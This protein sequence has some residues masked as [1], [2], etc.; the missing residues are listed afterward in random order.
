VGYSD[1]PAYSQ[2]FTLLLPTGEAA[3]PTLGPFIVVTTLAE[4]ER[5]VISDQL[6]QSPVRSDYIISSTEEFGV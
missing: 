1:I 2:M 3:T 5:L 6:S 4:L